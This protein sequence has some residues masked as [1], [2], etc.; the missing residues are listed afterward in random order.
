MGEGGFGKVFK[1]RMWE[2][3]G[4][5]VVESEWAIKELKRGISEYEGEGF[6]IGQER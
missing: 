5:G 2:K 4:E 6:K 1:G 3:R